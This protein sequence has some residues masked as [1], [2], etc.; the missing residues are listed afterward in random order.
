M[1]NG[2]REFPRANMS[3]KDTQHKHNQ[4]DFSSKNQIEWLKPYTC[5]IKFKAHVYFRTLKYAPEYAK[6]LRQAFR[7]NSSFASFRILETMTHTGK[8]LMLS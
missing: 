2:L 1:E 7:Q 4:V 3:Y 5:I 6:C 8:L